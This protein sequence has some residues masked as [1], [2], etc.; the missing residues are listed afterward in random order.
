[1]KGHLLGWSF[2]LACYTENTMLEFLGILFLALIIVIFWP[3]IFAFL[4]VMLC[5]FMA[6]LCWVIEVLN[7]PFRK[8][9]K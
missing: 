2:F 6:A 8:R 1:M 7:Y 4:V 9:P 3:L 5:L